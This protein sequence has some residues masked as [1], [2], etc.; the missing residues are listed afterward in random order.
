MDKSLG[1]LKRSKS[2]LSSARKSRTS[3]KTGETVPKM[4]NTHSVYYQQDFEATHSITAPTMSSSFVDDQQPDYHCHSTPR[5]NRAAGVIL[6]PIHQTLMGGLSASSSSSS[7]MSSSS[8]SSSTRSS[9]TTSLLSL[10]NFGGLTSSPKSTNS[11]TPNL[12]RLSSNDV[13]SYIDRVKRRS[14]RLGAVYNRH[15]ETMSSASSDDEDDDQLCGVPEIDQDCR[16]VAGRQECIGSVANKGTKKKKSRLQRMFQIKLRK[17]LNDL[18]KWQQGV[19]RDTED[20]DDMILN[21]LHSHKASSP[22]K[23]A[24]NNYNHHG[25]YNQATSVASHPFQ[26]SCYECFIAF[27]RFMSTLACVNQTTAVNWN[28]NHHPG[29][30]CQQTYGCVPSTHPMSTMMMMMMQQNQPTQSASNCGCSNRR[31]MYY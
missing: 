25:Q 21:K 6:S 19:M 24:Y 31:N 8:S 18:K 7:L 22:R 9:T 23:R 5:S 10:S 16:R 27:K 3:D 20:V 2:K 17:Q 29:Q 12:R 30:Y 11:S 15:S 28:F 1:W 14:I 4:I 13:L 26:C